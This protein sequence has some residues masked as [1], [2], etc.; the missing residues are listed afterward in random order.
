MFAQVGEDQRVE[1]EYFWHYV[2]FSDFFQTQT[3]SLT[4]SSNKVFCEQRWPLLVCR[5]FDLFLYV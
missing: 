5:I 1:L 4:F 2:T 3:P